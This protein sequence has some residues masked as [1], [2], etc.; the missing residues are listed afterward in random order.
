MPWTSS[1]TGETCQQMA[2]DYTAAGNGQFNANISNYSLFEVAH[3]ALTSVNNPH[4][5]TE[6]AAAIHKVN[7]NAL[8]GPMNFASS[9][10]PAPG[11]VITPP[12]GVQWQ[13]GTTYP[14]EMK[15][16]DTTLLSTVKITGD[17]LPTNT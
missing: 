3:A 16:V 13:K 15:V 17:L 9:S 12:V 11:V 6:V 1:F 14:L 8:A 4:D 10:A 7:I 2:D 5:K